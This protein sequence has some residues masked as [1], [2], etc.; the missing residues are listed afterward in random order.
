M[1]GSGLY[2]LLT[3]DLGNADERGRELASIQMR[4]CALRDHTK[5]SRARQMAQG[6][7]PDPPTVPR[8]SILLATNR[9][10]R[11]AGAIANVRRQNYP[12]LEIVL[13][14]H[15]GGF[16]GDALVRETEG[17]AMPVTVVPVAGDHPLGTVL[18][19]AA[20]AATGT[21]LT[22]M[23]DDDLYGP[24]HVWDLVLA[25]E[26]SGAQLVGKDI[27]FVFLGKTNRTIRQWLAGSETFCRHVAGGALLISRDDLD[28]IGGWR[29]VR[30]AVDEALI[31]DVHRAGATVYRT[32]GTGY[33]YVRHGHE[34]TWH[35]TDQRLMREAVM[36]VPGWHP[37]LAGIEDVPPPID[38]D[39]APGD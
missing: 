32:H 27:E 22:K 11:L 14:P 16:D 34:H 36:Q 1:L 4:R 38:M 9:P 21:L 15:G 6:R 18:N 31:E 13:A 30:R 8:V 7:L 17:L 37:S 2:E 5:K 39:T 10:H 26:Y 20:R 3:T 33:I 24:D 19:L 25:H 23:D 28:H 29:R 12:C 35:V